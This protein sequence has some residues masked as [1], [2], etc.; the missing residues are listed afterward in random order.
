MRK[1]TSSSLN[2]KYNLSD[3]SLSA[4]YDGKKIGQ[5]KSIVRINK[6]QCIGNESSLSSSEYGALRTH[7][8]KAG[9]IHVDQKVII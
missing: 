8:C 6:M 5:T 1:F 3:G 9:V 7:E 4:L 2:N